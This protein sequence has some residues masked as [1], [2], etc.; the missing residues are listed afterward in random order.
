LSPL[1][2]LM[3]AMLG[4]RALANIEE[5]NFPTAADWAEKSASAPRSHVFLGYFA[6]VAHALA[7][8]DK[9]SRY[10]ANNVRQRRPDITRQEF[11]KAFPFANPKLRSTFETKLMELGL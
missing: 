4:T 2:P 1:D 9:R 6:A 7:G 3:Y 5:N 8:N 11:F 10:W